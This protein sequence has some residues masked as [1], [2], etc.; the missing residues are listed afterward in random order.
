[1]DEWGALGNPPA[2]ECG[3]REGDSQ[4]E[5]SAPAPVRKHAGDDQ[6]ADGLLE[7][8]RR[9]ENALVTAAQMRRRQ[10]DGKEPTAGCVLELGESALA[11]IACDAID[12]LSGSDLARVRRC[13][14]CSLLF[15]DRSPPG[16]RRWCSMDSCGNREK[17]ARYRRT[18]AAGSGR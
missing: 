17:T 8:D 16:R 12:L 11:Q 15:L 5:P 13:A 6:G 4:H 1:M 10:L 7:R 2:C 9:L 18:R 3:A 14:G